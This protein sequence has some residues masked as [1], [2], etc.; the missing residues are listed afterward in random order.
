MLGILLYLF[1]AAFLDFISVSF[2]IAEGSHTRDFFQKLLQGPA[3]T[4]DY[5]WLRGVYK[6]AFTGKS[7]YSIRSTSTQCVIDPF[8]VQKL[9]MLVELANL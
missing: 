3:V 5:K 7:F 6:N 8:L 9:Q 4:Y 2:A 1:T